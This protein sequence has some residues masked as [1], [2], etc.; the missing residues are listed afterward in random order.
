M[1]KIKPLIV[2]ILIPLI[3]GGIGSLLGNTTEGFN[4]INKPEITPPSIVFPIVWII[5]YIIMGISSY[6]IYS[7]SADS[8]QKKNA[9]IFYGIQLI[10]NSLWTL[11]FFR[12]NLYLLSFF[13]IL[14]IIVFV[15]ITI[16][17]F[18]KIK[19]VAAYLLIPYLLW[20]V[21]AAILNFNIYAIN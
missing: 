18:Y 4:S 2:N 8:S 21:F 13:W 7:S 12:L 1:I 19:P 17:K 15:I 20:L 5:L 14:L 6:I 9:F 11:L 16:I 10:L 3:F